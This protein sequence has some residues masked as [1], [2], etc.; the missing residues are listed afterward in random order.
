MSKETLIQNLTQVR[1]EALDMLANVK[2]VRGEKFALG[3]Q[4]MLIAT[5]LADIANVMF[6]FV[7]IDDKDKG[8]ACMAGVATCVCQMMENTFAL[9]NFTDAETT[10]LIKM[11]ERMSDNVRDMINTAV[12]QEREGKGFGHAH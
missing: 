5:Q 8:A 4:S 7:D 10:D 3:L 12:Q 9:A 6:E 2:A 1:Q 11:H